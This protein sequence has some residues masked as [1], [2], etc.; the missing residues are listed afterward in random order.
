MTNKLNLAVVLVSLAGCGGSGDVTALRAAVDNANVK[1]RDTVATAEA[2]MPN[3]R[4][5]TAELRLAPVEYAIGTSGT[6]AFHDVRLDTHDGHIISSAA[7]TPTGTGECPGSISLA[8]AIGKAEARIAGG[9]VVAA[10]PDDDVACA[11]EIQVL[12]PDRLWEVKVAGDGSIL[13]VEESDET[14][15]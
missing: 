1:L 3:G 9:T 5:V 7:A 4:A 6:D 11:R 2:S 14:E 13:E 10:I 12:A 15:D 8:D